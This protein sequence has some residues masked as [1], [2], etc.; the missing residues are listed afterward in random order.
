MPASCP[1][2]FLCRL[3]STRYAMAHCSTTT[4][5]RI[6]T[7]ASCATVDFIHKGGH[8]KK[9]KEANIVPDLRKRGAVRSIYDGRYV[10]SRYFSP[11]QHN[12]PR[13]LEG[14]FALN[15]VELFDRGEDP[16]EI[17]NLAGDGSRRDLVLAMN[18]KLNRLI[19][20]EVGEDRGQMLP[21]GIDAG[22]EVT[23]ETMAP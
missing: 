10:F 8:P 16:L 6:S 2:I 21:G 14:R 15:D 5:S 22:W 20:S 9:L 7:A 17:Q 1:P 3:P 19:E 4:C 12:L 11:K 18:D 13:S 23:P